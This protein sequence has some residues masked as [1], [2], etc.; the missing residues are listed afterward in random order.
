MQIT[1]KVGRDVW[2]RLFGTR[3][4]RLGVDIEVEPICLES[5]KNGGTSC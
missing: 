1:V 2:F 5:G 3:M 4:D